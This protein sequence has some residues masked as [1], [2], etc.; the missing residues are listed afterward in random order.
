[1][2]RCPSLQLLMVK[3]SLLAMSNSL[4]VPFAIVRAQ[5]HLWKRPVHTSHSFFFSPHKHTCSL[6]S[7]MALWR[8]YSCVSQQQLW[9]MPQWKPSLYGLYRTMNVS[10][11]LCQ[12]PSIT[13]ETIW[14]QAWVQPQAL[15]LA[16]SKSPSTLHRI[17]S[18]ITSSRAERKTKSNLK[19]DSMKNESESI[20]REICDFI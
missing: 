13:G 1:M 19:K 15:S 17:I 5:C 16:C 14:Q 9:F 2:V 6:A 7:E 18:S 10:S 20:V 8:A 11:K 4:G 3:E 12:L